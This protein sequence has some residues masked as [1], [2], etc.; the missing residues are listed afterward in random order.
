VTLCPYGF[1]ILGDCTAER[2]LVDA[3]AA[4]RGYSLCDD[5][6]EVAREAYLSAFSFGEDFRQHL[7]STGSTKGFAGDCWAQFIW[8]DMDRDDLD[9]ALTDARRLAVAL[10][11][12]YALGDADL[13]IFFSGSKGFH[14]GLPTALWAPGPCG[15]FNRVARRFAEAVAE[16]AGVPIDTG[17]YD[18]VRPFRAPN[19]RH[20]KTALHKR[21]LSFDELM[22]LSLDAVCRLA[23]GPE[24]FEL[25]APAHPC[26]RAGTDWQ[27]A[28]QTVERDAGAK[29]N[30]RDTGNG[31]PT[32]NRVTLAFIRDGAADGDRHRLLYSAAANLAEFGCPPALAHAL[33]TEAALDSGLPPRD[34]RRQIECGMTGTSVDLSNADHAGLQTPDADSP[35]RPDAAQVRNALAE[36]WQHTAPAVEPPAPDPAPA[37]DERGNA[38]E[39]PE[40]PAP[41]VPAPT[42]PKGARLFFQDDRAR[43]CPVSEARLWTWEGA[44]RWFHVAD[45]P[46]PLGGGAAP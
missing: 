9:R 27:K 32:L 12:R 1:R 34:V 37:A 13:L 23:E 22:G 29:A 40:N 25:P 45:H 38:G 2:R 16:R 21:R 11:E 35:P 31:V 20:P 3:G 33:L 17:V 10:D 30:G 24:P 36:L 26:E 43:P 46:I 7:E 8:W 28:T 44:P 6:A 14:V 5:R 41:A 18:K 15:C 39:P 19:S 42:P 4:L